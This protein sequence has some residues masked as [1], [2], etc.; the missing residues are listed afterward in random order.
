MTRP[1]LD[2]ERGS[3][4]ATKLAIR[5]SGRQAAW[6]YKR[7]NAPEQSTG[8]VIRDLIEIAMEMEQLQQREWKRKLT[9][10]ANTVEINSP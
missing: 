6:V 5:V 8:K 1:L 3:G 2:P 4:R 9:E 7:A 10:R